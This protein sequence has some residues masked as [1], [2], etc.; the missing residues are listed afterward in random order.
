MKKIFL[1]FIVSIAAL[2]S[3]FE[4]GSEIKRVEQTQKLDTMAIIIE[5]SINTFGYINEPIKALLEKHEIEFKSVSEIKKSENFE[6]SL[7]VKNYDY[8]LN[9]QVDFIKNYS[10]VCLVS[11]S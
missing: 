6:F 11:S 7:I 3:F 8:L 10:F 9:K 2:L 5:D 4:L 1:K